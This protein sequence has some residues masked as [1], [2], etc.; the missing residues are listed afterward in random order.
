MWKHTMYTLTDEKIETAIDSIAGFVIATVSAETGRS[1]EEVAKL[2]YLSDI[3]GLLSDKNTGYY[4]DSI[5]EIIER[6]YAEL[7]AGGIE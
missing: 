6:F 7:A 3:Y 2:F 5:P 1:L 4:W